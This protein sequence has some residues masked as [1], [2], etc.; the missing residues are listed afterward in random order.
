MTGCKLCSMIL[1]I[2]I[3]NN[4]HKTMLYNWGMVLLLKC[5][6][7][8]EQQVQPLGFFAIILRT[9]VKEISFSGTF[10]FWL[11]QECV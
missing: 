3:Q 9:H 10:V 4:D 1:G 7:H 2:G 5:L 8:S 11:Q 6:E